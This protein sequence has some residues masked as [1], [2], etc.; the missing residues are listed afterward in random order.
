MPFWDVRAERKKKIAITFDDG[1]HPV[2]TNQILD[3]LKEHQVNA[4]FFVIGSRIHTYPMIAERIV[5]EGN[6]LGNH[7]MNHTY[8]DLLS[9]KEMRELKKNQRLISLH[10]SLAVPYYF[11]LLVDA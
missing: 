6:E 10:S 11:A 9:S 5:D 7:T 4:S 3:V 2:Y 8:F 1:P